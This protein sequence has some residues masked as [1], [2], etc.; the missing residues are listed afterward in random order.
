M[1]SSH[2]LVTS[3][4]TLTTVSMVEDEVVDVHHMGAVPCLEFAVTP[5]TTRIHRAARR[6][7]VRQEI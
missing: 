7:Q 6:L 5:Y 3:H 4:S 2:A 1:V